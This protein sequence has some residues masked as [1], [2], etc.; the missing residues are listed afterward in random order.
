MS[1]NERC[2]PVPHSPYPVLDRAQLAQLLGAL[3]VGFLSLIP[4]EGPLLYFISHCFRITAKAARVTVP[5][6]SWGAGRA[7]SQGAQVPTG[8]SSHPAPSGEETEVDTQDWEG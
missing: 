1:V 6:W 3:Q 7:G 8:Y 2:D 5:P 4:T